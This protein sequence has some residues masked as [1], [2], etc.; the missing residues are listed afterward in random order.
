MK[1][2]FNLSLVFILFITA[3]EDDTLENL[4]IGPAPVKL[5]S[6]DIVNDL[7]DALILPEGA[8]KLDGPVYPT[9]NGGEPTITS[10]EYFI[11]TANG[12]T[13]PIQLTYSNALPR[14][15]GFYVQ[16]KEASSYYK[17][18]YKGLP[19]ASGEITIPIGI[20]AIVDKG[21]FCLSFYVYDVAGRVSKASI[22]CFSVVR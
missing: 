8:K 6:P 16:V 22:S 4:I 10:P 3:C 9:N 1:I 15:G 19:T 12:T 18:P 7:S 5:L 20:P 21:E 11:V 17:I 13:T 2:L 14:L